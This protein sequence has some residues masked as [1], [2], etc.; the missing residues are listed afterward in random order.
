L[1]DDGTAIPPFSYISGVNFKQRFIHMQGSALRKSSV[2]FEFPQFR[3]EDFLEAL[4]GEYFSRN[5]GFTAVKTYRRS[6]GKTIMRYFPGVPSLAKE[7]FP[8]DQEFLFCVCP[9]EKMRSGVEEI[10]YLPALWAGLDI[11]PDGYSGGESFL[12]DIE[13]TALAVRVFPLPPSIVIESGRGLHL[14][15]LMAEPLLVSNKDIV[16]YLLKKLNSYFLCF[17]DVPLDS[18]LRLPGT[19]NLKYPDTKPECV[20]KYINT[21]FRYSLTDFFES[22]RT[23]EHC[24]SGSTEFCEEII[25]PRNMEAKV[26]SD[27]DDWEI[28]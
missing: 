23:I 9:F 27:P 14:Y 13:T 12:P 10:R 7:T 1:W 24:R 5:S 26:L 11:G 21:D 16:E 25:L 19:F 22:F 18:F 28:F 4:F 3:R 17:Q 20:V 2:D 6:D 15:W 8:P